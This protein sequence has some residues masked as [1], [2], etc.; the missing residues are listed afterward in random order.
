MT[1]VMAF[2]VA[3]ANLLPSERRPDYY[4]RVI[5]GIYRRWAR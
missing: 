5:D 4:D 3:F 2:V 1:R